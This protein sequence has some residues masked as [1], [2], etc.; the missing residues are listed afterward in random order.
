MKTHGLCRHPIHNS[1]EAMKARWS[2]KEPHK[3]KSY[4]DRGITVCDEWKDF[5]VFYDD[6]IGTW[7]PG[8]WIER[9]NNDLGYSK[10]NCKWATPTQ[11]ARN[12]RGNRL[13]EHGGK[14]E[15]IL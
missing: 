12:R 13:I 3:L 2:S 10:S 14:D 4:S 7:K 1:W 6:M 5:K 11:Q 15:A 8:L 9:T